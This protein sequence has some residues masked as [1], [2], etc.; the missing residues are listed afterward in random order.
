VVA[1]VAS[2]VVV[3]LTGAP[4]AADAKFSVTP[5]IAPLTVFDVLLIGTPSTTSDAL[6]PVTALVKAS[7]VVLPETVKSPGNPVVELTNANRDPFA[8]LM[9]L[10]CTPMLFVLMDSARLANVLLVESM[11]IVAVA[12]TPTCT[13]KLPGASTVVAA[14]ES[15]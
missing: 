8:S 10:A 15:V 12:P 1:C 3:I 7:P 11:V 5:L 2:G 9:T 4:G 13:L 14:N 6:D